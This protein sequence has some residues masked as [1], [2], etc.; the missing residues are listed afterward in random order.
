MSDHALDLGGEQVP[1][2]IRRHPTAKRMTLR[3]ASDGK[4]V[5]ITIPRWGRTREALR[6]A[7]ER[8]SWIAR[9][10]AARPEPLAIRNGARLPFR[11]EELLIDHDP[12]RSR[13]IV[14]EGATLVTGGPAENL[15]SRIERWLRA[16]MLALLAEDV[17]YFCAAAGIEPVPCRLTSARR[18][19]GSCSSA[20]TL[21]INWRLVMAPDFVRRSVVA[22]EVAHLVHFDHSPAF[23]ALCE[24]LAPG[25]QDPSD[26][27]LRA[28]GKT[29]HAAFG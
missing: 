9:Q 28:K 24:T 17:P 18:R 15:A 2:R 3:I 26:R 29:L 21:R 11:G 22:H 12:A 4:A 1:I 8:R 10:L 16:Q 6:F 7:N 5:A 27:W 23:H 13:R 20:G 25:L 14:R 19:W